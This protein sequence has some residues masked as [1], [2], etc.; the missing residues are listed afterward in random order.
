MRRSDYPPSATAGVLAFSYKASAA[1]RC[2]RWD[3]ELEGL[4]LWASRAMPVFLHCRFVMQML[5]QCNAWEDAGCDGAT[6]L[7]PIPCDPF[8]HRHEGHGISV[9][10]RDTLG[11]KWAILV[12]M[13]DIRE[14]CFPIRGLWCNHSAMGTGNHLALSTLATKPLS[15]LVESPP[16]TCLQPWGIFLLQTAGP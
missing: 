4:Q 16:R 2:Q 11:Q 6:L 8:R 12:R 7:H 1:G 15:T 3:T 5:V 13:T 10:W 9:E 14:F